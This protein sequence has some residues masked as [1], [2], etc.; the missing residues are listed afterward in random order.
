M[1][2]FVFTNNVARHNSYGIIGEAQSPGLPTINAFFPGGVIRRNVIA[3]GDAALYPVDN[4]FPS[5]AAFDAH[6]TDPA[7]SDYTLKPGTDWANAGTDGT[8]L[9]A[10]FQRPSISHSLTAPQNL[11]RI[12]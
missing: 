5:S 11:R 8:D 4:W 7:N 1:Q 9:G 10:N 12:Q 2:G 3:D 6:F